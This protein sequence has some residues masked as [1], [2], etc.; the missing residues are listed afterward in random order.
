MYKMR[1]VATVILGLYLLFDM[2]VHKEMS[3][4]HAVEVAELK[5][6]I[7][8]T[9]AEVSPSDI[10]IASG[11]AP[12]RVAKKAVRYYIPKGMKNLEAVLDRLNPWDE[13][14]FTEGMQPVAK[15]PTP[16]PEKSDQDKS[17]EFLKKVADRLKEREQL[18]K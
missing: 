2:G 9:V 4:A 3:E 5:A 8:K 11:H 10:Y 7:A 12:K 18:K 15:A 6:Q 16:K 17:L 13:V 1:E 14:V